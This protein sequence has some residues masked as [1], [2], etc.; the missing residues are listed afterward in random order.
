MCFIVQ[1]TEQSLRDFPDWTKE[2][3]RLVLHS[4]VD[5]AFTRDFPD[6]TKETRQTC[7]SYLQLIEHSP[8]VFLIGRRR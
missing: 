2:I 7:A 8:E 6:W 5:R 3:S 1:S 4:S